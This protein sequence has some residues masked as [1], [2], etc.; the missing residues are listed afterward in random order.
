MDTLTKDLRYALRSLLR[1]RGL[2]TVAVLCMGLGIGVCATLFATVNPWLFRPLPYAEAD[3]LMALGETSPQQGAS[4]RQNDPISGPN[5]LDWTLR[6]RSFDGAGAFD[7]T[8]LN[9]STEDEP[10][11]VTAARVTATLF[12]L[13]GKVPVLGRGL[14]PEDDRPGGQPVVLLGHALWL[15]H[16]GADPKAIGQTLKLDGKLFTV[17]GVMPPGFAFPEYAELWTPLRLEPGQKGRDDHR[18]DAIARLRPGVTV[19]QARAELDTIAASLEREYPDTNRERGARVLPLLEELTPPGVVAALRLLLVAGLLV[20]LIACANVANLMLARAAAQR[21]D[22]AVRLALGARRGQLLRQSLVEALLLVAAGAGLGLVL[23]AQGVRWLMGLSPISPPFWVAYDLDG[24]AVAFTVAV[25]TLS[26]LVVSLAPVL[27]ASRADVRGALK[28]GARTV[29]GGPRGRLGR[30]LVVSELGLSLVLLIGAAL[31]VR[32]FMHRFSADAGLDTRGVLTARLA[33]SGE[34]Y[35]DPKRRADFLE[36]LQRRLRQRPEVE[37]A[38]IANGLPL[39]DPLYGGWWERSYEV[40]GQPVE[41]E[42]LKTAAYSVATAGYLRAVGLRLVEGRVFNGT[43]EAEG[44]DVVVVSD[45]LAQRLWAKDALGRRLRLVDGP[46]LQVVGVVKQTRDNGN[47]LGIGTRP[48]DEIYVPYRRDPWDSVSVVVR[49]RSVPAAFTPLLRE[50]VRSLDP[51]LPLHSVFTLDEVRLRSVW[52]A[53]MWSRMLAAMAAFAL[54]LAGLGVY[55][56]V[57]Y[58]VSQR[59]HELGVRMAVGAGRGDVFRLVLGQG[60]RLALVAVAAGLAGAV[61]LSGALAGLLYGVDPLDPLT[62][63]GA[64]AA[65]TLIAL[66]ASYGPARRATRVDPLVALRSD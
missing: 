51:G 45:G 65:L 13:L 23:A 49:T 6:S 2:S 64:A 52:L 5:Y 9:L 24:R 8:E 47:L 53:E 54:L 17:V 29:A 42:K 61:A 57:S 26:A 39:P 19:E 66:A 10:E 50:A 63:V 21:Q 46:W 15:R 18:L 1:T 22:N 56:V 38:G 14:G 58:A 30:A 41:R 37:E 7:R 16:F 20:Q 34:A 3:R 25:T 11:R 60:L 44:R 36:E 28:E 59:T 40:E 31:M 33:L 55:G 35:A 12:P 43:E 48:E 27:Q 32:S 62:L 4:G